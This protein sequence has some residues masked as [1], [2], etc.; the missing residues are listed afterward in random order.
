[1]HHKS[2][3]DFF[4]SRL[5]NRS[6]LKKSSSPLSGFGCRVDGKRVLHYFGQVFSCIIT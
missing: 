4:L 5:A 2:Q 1:M 6:M 3:L